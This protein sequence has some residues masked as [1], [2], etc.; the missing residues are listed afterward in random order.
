[1][2]FSSLVVMS[3]LALAGHYDVG[4]LRVIRVKIYGSD[5]F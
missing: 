3:N 4:S 1:M 2:P 5:R